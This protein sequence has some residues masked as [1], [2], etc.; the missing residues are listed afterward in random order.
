VTTLQNFGINRDSVSYFVI[1][2]ASKNDTAVAHLADLYGSCSNTEVYLMSAD[3]PKRHFTTL[4]HI[5]EADQDFRNVILSKRT[6][7]S[8]E[9]PL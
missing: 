3:V 5:T 7:K 8:T 2:D 6:G 4:H 9:M 1:D